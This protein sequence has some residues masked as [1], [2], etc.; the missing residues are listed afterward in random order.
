[1]NGLGQKFETVA[2]CFGA[3]KK[4][5]SRCLTGEQDDLAMGGQLGDVDC[6][7][8]A[9]HTIHNDIA[10]EDVRRELPSSFDRV[11]GRV[12]S[13]RLEAIAIEDQ[14]ERVSDDLFIIE[15]EYAPG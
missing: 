5:W 2:A 9:G 4:I 6:S 13:L 7:L 8:D 11:H 3:L 12:D 15:D 10:Y 14:R 1:M